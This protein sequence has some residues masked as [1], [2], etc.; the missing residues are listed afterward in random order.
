MELLG[1]YV[2]DTPPLENGYICFDS[3]FQAEVNKEERT[4]TLTALGI[5]SVH[6][7]SMHL[8]DETLDPLLSEEEKVD[9][10]RG[11]IQNV[12]LI[13]GNNGSGKTTLCFLLGRVVFQL[14]TGKRLDDADDFSGLSLWRESET[15]ATG[16]VQ[17]LWLFW[18]DRSDA[19][20]WTVSSQP[21]GQVIKADPFEKCS[22][23]SQ[24]PDAILISNSL[25]NRRFRPLDLEGQAS[26]RG[27]LLF[28]ELD[29]PSVGSPEFRDVFKAT[30]QAALSDYTPQNVLFLGNG[31]SNTVRRIFAGD[32]PLSPPYGWQF[33]T[34]QLR[35]ILFELWGS[36]QLKDIQQAEELTAKLEPKIAGS[37][38]STHIL[39]QVRLTLLR[40]P[41]FQGTGTFWARE[42]ALACRNVASSNTLLSLSPLL[43]D[44]L[45]EIARRISQNGFS[46]QDGEQLNQWLHDDAV[47]RASSSSFMG[48]DTSTDSR[49]LAFALNRLEILFRMEQLFAWEPSKTP[50]Q[51]LLSCQAY[52][53]AVGQN[54][55]KTVRQAINDYLRLYS[56][57]PSALPELRLEGSSGQINYHMLMADLLHALEYRD[58][59]PVLLIVDEADLSFHPEWQRTFLLKL[60]CVLSKLSSNNWHVILATHSPILLSDFPA[61]SRILL[62]G[63]NSDRTESKTGE[64]D[65]TFAQNIYRL[66]S[67]Q[68]HLSSA[69]GS[70]AQVYLKKLATSISSMSK[71]NASAQYK[72]LKAQI[73]LIGDPVLRQIK[74]S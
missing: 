42:I 72:A 57:N 48:R 44:R 2:M 34:A 32:P 19:I 70:F 15:E 30:G 68:M 28:P 25:E 38:Q 62:P 22:F 13:I 56:E 61:S 49:N 8:W 29:V 65:E 21:E 52:S 35:W 37:P 20:P 55:L 31:D 6:P 14:K 67:N 40:P 3:R 51:I 54:S 47:L 46:A 27:E 16:G 60:L 17:Q 45:D 12:N 10:I 24:I 41:G 4:V 39:E 58:N 43:I 5:G 59:S 64:N 1:I 11:R 33:S 69:T 9:G 74:G 71:D 36:N 63:A 50:N 73:E 23:Y 53:N 26:Q 18:H 7:S 66:Y